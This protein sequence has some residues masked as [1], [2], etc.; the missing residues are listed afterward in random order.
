MV[1]LS[2]AGPVLVRRIACNKHPPA[3]SS[4]EQFRRFSMDG[5][6]HGAYGWSIV[7]MNSVVSVIAQW[8]TSPTRNRKVAGSIP[9]LTQ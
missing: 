7:W 2:S 9:G 8:L 5:F 3:L 6:A 1:L 4:S